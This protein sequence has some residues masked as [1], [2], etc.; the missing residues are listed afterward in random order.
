M[1]AV[2]IAGALAL[3][4]AAS[5]YAQTAC[6]CSSTGTLVAAPRLL[7]GGNTVCA[8]RG[9]E[10]W[11]EYHAG[12][13]GGALIDYKR[14]PNDP[15]DPTA[16]V[17]TW[18]ASGGTLTHDYGGGARYTWSVCREA[19]GGPYRFCD[20]STSV[21]SGATIVTGQQACTGLSQRVAPVTAAPPNRGK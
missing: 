2:V 19:P 7:V 11:Q 3:G 17:G 14:G 6:P 15:V 21:V 8:A 4:L 12:T 10:R 5:A 16:Q 9:D 1:K 18:S 20:G 13:S